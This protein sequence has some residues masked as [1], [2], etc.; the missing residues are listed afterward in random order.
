VATLLLSG[1]SGYRGLAGLMGDL[2]LGGGS[3]WEGVGLALELAATVGLWAWLF[4]YISRRFERQADTFAVQH[5]AERMPD[6]ALGPGT[7]GPAA[8][9]AMASALEAVCR[10]NHM[11]IQ[12]HNWRHGSVQWRIDYLRELVG[13]PIDNVPVDRQVRRIRWACTALL[14]AAGYLQANLM[15]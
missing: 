4:G 12:R 9:E 6:P 15:S 1:Y 3:T 10:L 5:L 14:L 11:P 8:A 2:G 7:I 13:R